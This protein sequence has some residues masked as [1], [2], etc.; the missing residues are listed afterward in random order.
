MKAVNFISRILKAA[1]LLIITVSMTYGQN[2]F[3]SPGKKKTG[4][5]VYKCKHVG[6]QKIVARKFK[7]KDFNE[8]SR[9][10]KA[11]DKNIT[12]TLFM[13]PET[14]PEL[15]AS[16]SDVYI[17]AKKVEERVIENLSIPLPKPVY[18]RFD[19][20]DLTYEDI[21]QIFLAIEHI[22]RGSNII[23]EGHTDS[24]GSHQYNRALSH[25]RAV[26]IKNM[27]VEMG[28]VNPD[29]ITIRFYGEERPAVE[30]SSD[31]NRQLNRRVEF[32]VLQ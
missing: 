21:E 15:L 31:E 24:H 27:I 12:D 8:V 4:K 1:I 30:N 22:N 3:M 9:S 7:V 2:N 10:R 26:R 28:G 18:F 32:V 6:K 17:E 19:T 14:E 25:K 16:T 20:D 29:R 23:L 5:R 11:T 13:L